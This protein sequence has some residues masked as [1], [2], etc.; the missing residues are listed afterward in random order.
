MVFLVENS[1]NIPNEMYVYEDKDW[2]DTMHSVFKDGWRARLTKG[3]I[4]K[5]EKV[6]KLKLPKQN[7]I[8]N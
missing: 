6:L 4:D 8:V 7:Y 3:Y 2:I 5:L 1:R